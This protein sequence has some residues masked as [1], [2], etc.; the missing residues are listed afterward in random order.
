[1][2]LS[3]VAIAR[4]PLHPDD[5]AI[6]RAVRTA[7]ELSGGLG[8]VVRPGDI[9]IIKPNLVAMPPGREVGA[10]TRASVCAA[11]ADLVAKAGG[12]PIIAESSARGVDTEEVMEYL[13]YS[14]LRRRGYEVV[15][16]KK[17]PTVKVPVPGGHVL[18]QVTT[19]EL[20]L[21]ADVIISV[22]VIKTHDQTEV[23]L[24]LKNLKGLVTDAEKRRIHQLG[25]FEGVA[26]LNA[27]FRPA[28]AVVDGITAQEGLGPVY[29]LPVEMGLVLAGRDLVA[30]DAVTARTMGFV[31][32]EIAILK[33]A[34]ERGLGL[35]DDDK[36]EVVG[37]RVEEVRRR[38]M[39]MEEDER[40]RLQDVRVIHAEGSCTGCR[41]G[42]LS[43]LFDMIQAGT[44]EQARGFT[45]VTGGALA[46]AGTPDDKLVPVGVC[47]P[48]EL[49]AHPRYVKGCPPNNVD[50]I[51]AILGASLTD[52][53]EFTT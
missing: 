44:I 46:P 15:D 28:F 2:S 51:G 48:K 11:V 8:G 14:D 34:A 18:E 30:V 32:A 20:A 27:L 38:F 19:Y 5:D 37:A 29:G 31:P 12:K 36:I 6:A 42:V 3:T 7:V 1:M 9:V 45:L 39:R 53:P 10:C 47:C 49:Q 41:N 16:L 13:G 35:L 22:P 43:S 52:A 23:T 21:E 24:S 17:T 26:D 25:V 50:I 40:I 33:M 4:T